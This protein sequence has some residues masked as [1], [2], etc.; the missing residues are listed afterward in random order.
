[1]Y[2][3]RFNLSNGKN[4]Q[5]WKVAY[6]SG[7]VRYYEP[8]DVTIEMYGCKL[9]NQKGTAKKIFEGANKSTCAWVECDNLKLYDAQDLSG[10]GN[11]LKVSYNPRKAPHWVY[12][13]GNADSQEFLA[14]VTQGRDILNFNN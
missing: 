11:P 13:D 1:M 3:V 2:K 5:K 8:K 9:R 4:F 14:L 6:P 7:A 12:E 10:L